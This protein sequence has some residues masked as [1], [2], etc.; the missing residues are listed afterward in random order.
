GSFGSDWG[1]DAYVQRSTNNMTNRTPDN[2]I[3][4]NYTRAIDAVRDPGTGNIVCRS[5]LSTPD[6]G[7]VPY[8]VLGVGVAS[9]AGKEYVLGDGWVNNLLKQDSAGASVHGAPFSTWAGPV[10]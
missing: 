7:C 3:R 4:A 8:N 10:S 5:T 1:W 2:I 9:E 6:D